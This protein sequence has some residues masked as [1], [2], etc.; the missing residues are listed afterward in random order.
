MKEGKAL[1]VSLAE[2]GLVPA[3]AL[4]MIEV[5][6]ASGALTAMLTALRNST[7]KKSASGCNVR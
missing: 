3:L 7:K 2:T 4:E 5:G 6:E 1:H